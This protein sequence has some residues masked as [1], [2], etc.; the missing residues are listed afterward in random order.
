MECYP[1]LKNTVRI[2]RLPGFCWVTELLYD[3]GAVLSPAEAFLLAHCTG[4]YSMED[5]EYIVTGVFL[6]NKEETAGFLKNTF[7]NRRFCIEWLKEQE[8]E[9]LVRYK[10]Q[11]FLY[12]PDLSVLKDRYQT[13][14][15]MVLVLTNR[16]NF[17]CIYCYN[18]SGT[19]EI[20]KE[21]SLSQWLKLIDEAAA[22]GVVKCTLTGGEPMLSPYFFDIVK[23]LHRHD[24]LTYICTNGSLI[25]EQAVCQ[26]SKLEVP[27]VQI[28]MDSA[29]DSVHDK[30]TVTKNTLPKVKSAIK[31]LLKHGVR[32]HVKAVILPETIDDVGELIEQCHELGVPQLIIDRY[33]LCF[34]GRGSNDFFLSEQ[35]EQDVKAIVEEK[36]KQIGTEMNISTVFPNRG[37]KNSDDIVKCGAFYRSFTVLP[38]GDYPLCEK[39]ADIPG[40][41]VGNYNEIPLNEMWSSSNISEIMQPKPSQ[42]NPVCRSCEYLPDCGTGC[43]ASKQFVTEDIYAP[44]PNCWKADYSDNV[45]IAEKS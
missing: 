44:D 34:L 13:P 29:Y 33:D 35:Q 10:P 26:F 25:D 20:E 45:F 2:K 24:I 9:P 14:V 1:K 7:I 32:V 11:D 36:K 4:E 22:M 19:G 23:A 28:S 17:R 12:N 3:Y 16:C 8:H 27:L 6:W 5:L 21:L 37:W 40:L 18:S 15:E 41:A 30:L 42:I 31:K 43:F 39:V 38:D